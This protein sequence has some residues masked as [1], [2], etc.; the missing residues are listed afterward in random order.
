MFYS[1]CMLKFYLLK[2]KNCLED[3]LKDCSEDYL[4][5]WL[6]HCLKNLEISWRYLSSKTL[7]KL[8]PKQSLN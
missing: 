2:L 8:K 7:I 3:Y 5:D 1:W 4:E 6:K